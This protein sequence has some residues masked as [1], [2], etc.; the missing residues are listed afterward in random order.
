MKIRIKGNS[1]RMRITRSEL[2]RIG[3]DGEIM[4][5]TEFGHATLTYIL[6][7]ADIDELYATF[8]NNTITM[9]VPRSFARQWIDTDRVGFENYMNLDNGKKLFLLIEKDFKCLDETHEDQT[10]NFDNPLLVRNQ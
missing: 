1:V 10:D 6:K 9:L 3:T 8:D 2:D 4:E 5:R 7:V